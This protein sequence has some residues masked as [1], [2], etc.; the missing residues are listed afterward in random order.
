[1]LKLR[2]GCSMNLAHLV[3]HFIIYAGDQGLNFDNSI[4]PL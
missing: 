4:Y 2:M 3:E 1:M